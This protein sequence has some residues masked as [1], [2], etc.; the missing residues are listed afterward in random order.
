[1]SIAF[2]SSHFSFFFDL[3]FFI[4][5]S[6]LGG[7]ASFFSPYYFVSPFW[8]RPDA[9]RVLLLGWTRKGDVEMKG[10]NQ[11]VE[12]IS[13][14]GWMS[15][16]FHLSIRK[17]D[18][19]AHMGRVVR[20]NW[21]IEEEIVRCPVPIYILQFYRQR[22]TIGAIDFLSNFWRD[23]FRWI[24]FLSSWFQPCVFFFLYFHWT[25]QHRLE[26]KSAEYWSLIDFHS[27]FVLVKGCHW[28]INKHKT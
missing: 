1:M 17:R 6:F 7:M 25:I 20:W 14:V 11:G 13:Q 4:R 9:K 28:I 22:W 18:W 19:A 12:S 23:F 21:R 10:L 3:F 5:S 2:R 26:F 15:G 27:L 8:W 24:H 16:D